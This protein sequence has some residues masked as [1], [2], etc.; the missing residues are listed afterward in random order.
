M[1]V[2]YVLKSL[3]HNK[4]YTGSTFDIKR[5]LIEHNNGKSIYTKRF[6]PWKVI[7]TEECVKILD[8]RKREKYLKTSA[9]RRFLKSIPR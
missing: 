2:V 4:F 1:P 5:R 8:A 7:Y 9:G 3:N 6:M